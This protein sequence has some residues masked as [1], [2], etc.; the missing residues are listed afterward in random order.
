MIY[1]EDD[2]SLSVP[3]GGAL[4][5]L[6]SDTNPGRPE[7]TEA[8]KI[9]PECLSMLDDMQWSQ[10]TGQLSSA[11]QQW[12]TMTE[13]VTRVAAICSFVVGGVVLLIGLLAGMNIVIAGIV[14]AAVFGV[15]VAASCA[16]GSFLK[17][18]NLD[19]DKQIH[20]ICDQL[21]AT[22]GG[23]VVVEYRK[24]TPVVRHGR[25]RIVRTYRYISFAKAET[26]TTAGA[27]Q[28]VPA[29]VTG[30]DQNSLPGANDA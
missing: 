15:G 2:F 20:G 12:W 25:H 28:A 24:A 1:V 4:I 16:A 30:V 8:Q 5:T 9:K 26:V 13:K 17:S 22:I 6:Q 10:F 21:T 3:P 27:V 14:S 7:L 29:T 19:V 18:R 23:A 11:L